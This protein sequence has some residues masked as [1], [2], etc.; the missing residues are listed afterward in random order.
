MISKLKELVNIPSVA[1]ETAEIDKALGKIKE[2]LGNSF[3]F[4]E[5]KQGSLKSLLVS[6]V[7]KTKFKVLLYGHIDVVSAKEYE[8]K[9]EH[10]KLI[11][12]GIYDMKGILWNLLE[13][14]KQLSS[15]DI[16]FLI[17][18]D[19]EIG[20]QSTKLACENGVSAEIVIMCDSGDEKTIITG[21][22]GSVI[23][24]LEVSG[25]SCHSAYPEKGDNPILKLPMV[26]KTVQQL[27]LEHQDMTV[28]PT[29]VTC[30]SAGNKVPDK[31]GMKLNIRFLNEES[32]NSAIKALS[33]CGEIKVLHK[34]P[35]FKIDLG[36]PLAKKYIE[37]AE[38]KFGKIELETSATTSDA[39]Y[40]GKTPV[41]IHR[42]KGGGS[43]SEHEWL[44]IE[45]MENF[46]ALVK[47]FL[48]SI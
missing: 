37:L 15:D 24:E 4:K 35:I 36:S 43:H 8:L 47:E 5:Y 40:F 13:V 16:G 18:T 33:G 27:M 12:R 6:K 21:H 19:E 20:G 22:K 34:D 11:G 10:G 32:L 23:C 31:L 14:F 45:S 25:K 2:Y 42:P 38:E 46:K 26:I 28:V 30:G 39:V 7:P 44:D 29:V 1:G 3:C 9:E 48:V 41:I 17:S